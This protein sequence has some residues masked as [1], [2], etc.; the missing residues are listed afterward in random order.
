MPVR[1]R[2]SDKYS[3]YYRDTPINQEEQ[4][5]EEEILMMSLR[6]MERVAN[7]KAKGRPFRKLQRLRGQE[8]LPDLR[9]STSR[10]TTVEDV[11]REEQVAKSQ[12][13]AARIES[14]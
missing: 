2:Q 11:V 3:K 1:L 8:G 13:K 9:S 6:K 12:G 4:D 10:A 5:I 14:V 7:G